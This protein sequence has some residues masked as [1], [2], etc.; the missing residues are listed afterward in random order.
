MA[1][2]ANSRSPVAPVVAEC[3]VG[4]RSGLP[5]DTSSCG[6]SSSTS[7]RRGVICA[8]T[9]RAYALE[10]AGGILADIGC[11]NLLTA[12]LRTAFSRPW[13][14][15]YI[16]SFLC[17]PLTIFVQKRQRPSRS[18]GG[19]REKGVPSSGEKIVL[20]KRRRKQSIV[21]RGRRLVVTHSWH[22]L[23]ALRY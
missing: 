2:Q 19:C 17:Q 1:P 7:S 23:A 11:R 14:Q 15:F 5:R 10:R 3:T 18:D 12:V 21:P 4:I 8:V 9:V 16:R 13:A 20:T 22:P 6:H